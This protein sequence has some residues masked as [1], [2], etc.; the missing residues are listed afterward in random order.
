M[1]CREAWRKLRFRT[2]EAVRRS[3]TRARRRSRGPSRAGRGSGSRR[4]AG[5]DCPRGPEGQCP[6]RQRLRWRLAFPVGMNRSGY[7]QYREQALLEMGRCVS[8]GLGW[9]GGISQPRCDTCRAE[10]VDRTRA[11]RARAASHG[12][13]A[14]QTRCVNCRCSDL[15]PRAAIRSLRDPLP[16]PQTTAQGARAFAGPDPVAGGRDCAARPGPRPSCRAR[17][18]RAFAPLPVQAVCRSAGAL[19]PAAPAGPRTRER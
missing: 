19:G 5:C 18:A 10:A 8:C 1:A 14:V 16:L 9:A 6:V 7:R 4:A 17:E 12:P 13:G 2:P 11:Y 3:R 15:T